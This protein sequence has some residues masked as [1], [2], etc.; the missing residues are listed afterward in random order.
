MLSRLT[1]T[2]AEDERTA[3]QQMAEADCRYPRDQIR[4]LVRQAAQQH[5]LLRGGAKE[6]ERH[7]PERVA[8]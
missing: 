8:A 6:D 1:I 7:E 5:G 3:L 2:L 4:Y